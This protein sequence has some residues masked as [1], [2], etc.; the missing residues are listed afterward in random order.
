MVASVL[1]S[2]G[3]CELVAQDEDEYVR[4]AVGLAND[5]P[6]LTHLRETLRARMEQSPL[7]DASRFARDIEAAYR[8]MWRQWCAKSR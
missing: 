8:D 6:R 2:L 5:L 1:A 4:L 3:L 7:T